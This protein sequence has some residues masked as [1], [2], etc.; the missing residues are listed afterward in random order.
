MMVVWQGHEHQ[1]SEIED[2]MQARKM[3]MNYATQSLLVPLEG[4][5]PLRDKRIPSGGHPSPAF[6]GDRSKPTEGGGW[7]AARHLEVLPDVNV[8]TLTNS[9]RAVATAAERGEQ[10]LRRRLGAAPPRRQE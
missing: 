3:A 9:L 2:A 4:R 6:S 5:T 7:T 1:Q 10:K 8:N